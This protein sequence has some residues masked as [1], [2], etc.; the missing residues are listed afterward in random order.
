MEF[1][2]LV[3]IYIFETSKTPLGR[4]ATEGR[5][6]SAHITYRYITKKYLVLVLGLPRASPGETCVEI[7]FCVITEKPQGTPF[8]TTFQ[9]AR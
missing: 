7:E 5:A 2:K 9:L 6:A 1:Y 3:P 8:P 4:I